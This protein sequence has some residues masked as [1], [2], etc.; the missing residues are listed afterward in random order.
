[1]ICFSDHQTLSPSAQFQMPKAIFI[2]S[3]IY[4]RIWVVQAAYVEF[5]TIWSPE[6]L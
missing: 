5:V 1:M 2:E 4:S 6:I 3:A